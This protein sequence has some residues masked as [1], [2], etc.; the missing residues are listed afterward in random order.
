[1]RDWDVGLHTHLAETKTQAVL[2][3]RKY[4]RSLTAHL[5]GLGLLGE[6]T[7]VAHA[8]WI[9]RDDIRCLADAGATVAHNPMSNLRL[10]SGVAPVRLMCDA[11]L[12]VGVGTDASNTSDGQNMFEA[13]RL[14]AY[15]SRLHGPDPERWLAAADA[16]EMATRGSA[17]ALGM[18]GI[19]RIAP[20]CR[21]DLVFLDLGQIH[22]VPLRAPLLQ[23]VFA[24]NGAAVHSVM[25][26][27]RLIL[28]AGRLLTID[29]ASLRRRAE[30]AAA[31]LD[32]ANAE[33]FALAES[34]AHIVGAFCIAHA[35]ADHPI[36]RWLPDPI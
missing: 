7:S 30:E 27:G 28:E 36:H 26:D 10:G 12:A 33:S 20:G 3:R 32:A 25:V 8:I 16:F 17:R 14:T 29:E 18:E 35:R 15:L 5:A 9:D 21:A 1:M 23:L 19:G 31:R 4:G 13:M 11:G 22:Y 24:E 2:G 6:R 34:A